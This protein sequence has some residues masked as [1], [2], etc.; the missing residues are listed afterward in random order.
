MATRSRP[1]AR[2]PS[3]RV[4]TCRSLGCTRKR[5]TRATRSDAAGQA[6][7]GCFGQT[8]T[9]ED[10]PFEER[11]R[12]DGCAHLLAEDGTGRAD[13]EG[14]GA[15]QIPLEIIDPEETPALLHPRQITQLDP[16][17]GVGAR[18]E[19][20]VE[21]LRLERRDQEARGTPIPR[22]RA[23]RQQLARLLGVVAQAAE[24]LFAV[25]IRHAAAHQFL[26]SRTNRF[27]LAGAR[28]D[29]A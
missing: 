7:S 26:G 27:D 14:L 13:L 16:I 22:W 20:G 23:A 24:A 10:L 28:R 17:M 15:G 12:A 29:A 19:H 8:E 4:V 3:S 9:I 1:S 5:P 25:A 2:H 18:I 11:S 6:E 21:D